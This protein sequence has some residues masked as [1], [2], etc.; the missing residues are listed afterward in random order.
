MTGDVD[1]R[2]EA[3][4]PPPVGWH[5]FDQQAVERILDTGPDGLSTAEHEARVVRH[6]PNQLREAPGLSTLTI[7]WHQFESPLVY[8][9][10]LAGVISAL[11]GEYIDAI[12]ISAV[13]II[14]AAIGF[15]Q[16]RQAERSVD[17]LLR[18]VAPQARVIRDGAELQVDSRELVPGDLVLLE[19]GVR[20]PADLRLIDASML[21]ADE[22]LLTGESLPVAK[23]V[24]PVVS[25]TVAVADRTNMAFAGTNVARGRGR[26]YVVATGQQTALG[27]IAERVRVEAA[28]E[29]PLQQ[30]MNRLARII[31]VAVAVAALLVFAI[32]L[33]R[34]Y[35]VSRMFTV[36]VAM[37][38][39]AV[40]EGLPVAFTITLAIGVRRMARRNAI[41]RRLP[42]VEALGSTTT[43]GS[44]KTGTLTENRMT[45]RA[46]WA[47]GT[48]Y[49]LEDGNP[50]PAL[51]G[52]HSPL[53]LT[54]L[55]GVLANEARLSRTNGDLSIQ[56]DPTD[57]ALLLV[58]TRLGLDVEVVRARYQFVAEVP[59]E[60]ER[61]YAASV[62]GQ[63]D[64]L[65]LFVKGAPERVLAMCSDV[66]TTTDRPPVD[67]TAVHQ[68]AAELAARGL[69]VL[70]MAVGP[71]SRDAL[72]DDDLTQSS[73][74]SFVGLQGML[75]PP[76]TGV[77]DA[78][79]ACREAGIRVLMITGDHAATARSI[80]QAVGLTSTG[81]PVLTGTELDALDDTQLRQRTREVDIY[82]RVAPEHKLRIVHGL[83]RNGEV[84]AVTGDGVNDAP[85][86]KVADIGVAM[87]KSG[88]DVAREV[89]DIILA[90]DNFVSIH[91]AVEEGRV[92]FDNVRKAT[93]FLLGTGAAEIL[94][95]L[96]ALVLGWRMPLLAAQLLWLNLVTDSL[97]VLALAFEPGE[98]DVLRRP[99][100]PPR[101]GIMS[102]LLWER[103][104]LSA[105]VMALGTLFLFRWELDHGA[106]L[107]TAQTVALTA[108][109]LYQMF[110]VGN[111][112]SETR[113][114][115]RMSPY[116]NPFLLL[117]A[118]A[119][120]IVHAA[121]LD[122]LPT[123]YVL[124]VEPIGLLSWVRIA[125]VAS[126]I[127]V[128]VELHKWLRRV[129]KEPP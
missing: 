40:P 73:A 75:D 82:A 47:D 83:Q 78:I 66:L 60:P 106:S 121:A 13:L 24:A 52:E 2:V 111:A 29:T 119:A 37:A 104:G 3:E 4:S 19:S 46:I 42:A 21:T 39:S 93:F 30:R 33:A 35:S 63:G 25:P 103:V 16:E 45:V 32:G 115:F 10:L 124:R 48:H 88:T 49:S 67:L 14:N 74:L 86:L 1:D 18:L 95:I 101:E 69:R 125:L 98:P 56:G 76:R 105:A 123:Q 64:H 57:A 68:A 5:T 12:A 109:V 65:Q 127:L 15:V 118:I 97:Q 17:A 107:A 110:Q 108:M 77:P 72:D 129:R 90:D 55:T 44:D 81:T 128:A 6:G 116:S 43:I 85:A 99:P 23:Q 112:R 58:A 31:S 9:L 26:G 50:T 36:A 7:L 80:A 54:L 41:V 102:W 20:V 22:S 71:L 117:A 114:L 94:T 11:L 79:R 113:S 59:F 51:S 100:R 28:P 122:L 84:V 70:A 34:G 89:A 91:A 27:A 61:Q 53:Y 87:G 8:V 92:T 62:R 38:V 96:L 120:I 126:S